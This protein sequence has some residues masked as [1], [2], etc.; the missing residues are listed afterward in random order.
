MKSIQKM[1]YFPDGR[2][3]DCLNQEATSQDRATNDLIRLYLKRGLIADGWDLSDIAII[4]R[5][6]GTI[7]RR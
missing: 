1:L 3:L 4:G 6:K 5:Q 2:L 7:K